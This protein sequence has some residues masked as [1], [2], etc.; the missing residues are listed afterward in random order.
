ML[1]KDSLIEEPSEDTNTRWG[2]RWASRAAA[3]RLAPW[4]TGMVGEALGLSYYRQ[5]NYLTNLGRR[6]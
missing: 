3:E 2:E 1:K 4:Q 5:R 6:L